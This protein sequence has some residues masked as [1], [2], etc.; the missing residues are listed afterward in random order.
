MISWTVPPVKA[1][2][3]EDGRWRLDLVTVIRLGGFAGRFH[4]EGGMLQRTGFD[5][6]ESLSSRIL[7][8]SS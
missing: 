5:K 8:L 1:G 3:Q 2:R 6:P 7:L 4:S